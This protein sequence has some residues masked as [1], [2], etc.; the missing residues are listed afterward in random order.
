MY[1]LDIFIYSH[2]WWNYDQSASFLKMLVRMT[3]ARRILEIGTFTG[4][5]ALNMA[6]ALPSD[7]HLVTMEILPFFAQFARDFLSQTA[8]KDKVDVQLG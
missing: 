8:Y 5:G 7:G 6:E 3:G 1:I 4:F 2:F